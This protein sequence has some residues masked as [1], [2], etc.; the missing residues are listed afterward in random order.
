MIA[1]TLRMFGPK[2]T[3]LLL[4][5]AAIIACRSRHVEITVENRTGASI[6]LLEVD[7]PSASFGADALPAYGHLNYA[8]Q[9]R[10]TGPVKMQYKA[11]G[12]AQQLISGPSL[13]EGAEGSLQIV[14][15]PDGKA[16]FTPQLS[17]QQ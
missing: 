1:R 13:T 10:G 9:V 5:S 14:L 4:T 17:G 11:T 3:I 12:G 7:Y 15:L 16:E 8:I 2:F 6:Q